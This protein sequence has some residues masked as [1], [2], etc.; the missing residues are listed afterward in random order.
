M[1]A[2]RGFVLAPRALSPSGVCVC[3]CVCVCMCVLVYVCLCASVCLCVAWY[4]C[5][6]ICVWYVCVRMCARALRV[7]DFCAGDTDNTP[8]PSGTSSGL[9]IVWMQTSY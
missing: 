4:V 1:P 8:I 2:V 6:R 3:A 5:A 7:C 9:I